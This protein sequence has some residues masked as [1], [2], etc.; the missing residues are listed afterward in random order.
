MAG[1][2]TQPTSSEPEPEMGLVDL[3]IAAGSLLL[4]LP[5][6]PFLA[7]LWLADRRRTGGE[8]TAR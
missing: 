5:I 4:M 3:L 1:T 7:V 8:A 2:A 6:L